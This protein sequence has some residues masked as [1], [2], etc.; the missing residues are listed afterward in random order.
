[1]KKYTLLIL[2]LGISCLISSCG[3]FSSSENRDNLKHLKVGMTKQEVLKVMGEPLTKEIYNK[4]N[5]WF[6]Y[7]QPRWHDS[8]M[9]RDEC[10]PLVFKNDKL[11]GW[12]EEYY[13]VNYRFVDWEEESIEDALGKTGNNKTEKNLKK[14]AEEILKTPEAQ[15]EE[16]KLE[17]DVEKFEKEDNKIEKEMKN[18][19]QQR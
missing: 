1:M 17:K 15:K 13:K 4:P 6:Y 9:T 3:Y 5:L 10:T 2:V 14:D 16:K 12:G 7:T 8:V 18:L 19:G 11:A